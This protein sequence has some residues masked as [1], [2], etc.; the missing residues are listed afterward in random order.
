M[1]NLNDEAA[2]NICLQKCTK[3]LDYGKEKLRHLSNL[4]EVTYAREEYCV[5]STFHRGVYHPSPVIDLLVGNTKRGM[6]RNRCPSNRQFTHRYKFDNKGALVKVETYFQGRVAYTEYLYYSEDK[7]IG[8]TIDNE[9]RLAAVTEETF[10]DNRII[11][12]SLMNCVLLGGKYECINLQTETY[13]YDPIGLIESQLL[14]LTPA[15]MSLI[16]DRY[17]WERENGYLTA[18]TNTSCL[19]GQRTYQVKK[20][21]LAQSSLDMLGMPK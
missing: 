4:C 17:L 9:M 19:R 3:L 21:R 15:G 1:K 14:Q 6:L 16:N 12:F 13:Y 2:M 8:V 5:N 20:R 18:Y 7:R 10:A 11:E